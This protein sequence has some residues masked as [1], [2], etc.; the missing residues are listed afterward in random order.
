M[1]KF[2]GWVFEYDDL[3]A[4]AVRLFCNIRLHGTDIY[5]YFA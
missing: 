4:V 2:A 3:K 1:L 5:F